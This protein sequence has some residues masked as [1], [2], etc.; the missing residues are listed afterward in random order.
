MGAPGVGGSAWALAD[1]ARHAGG[2]ADHGAA[3]CFGGGLVCLAC[4]EAALAPAAPG[5]P[6][7]PGG[8][9][10]QGLAG[11][12]LAREARLLVVLGQLQAAV[13]G[14]AEAGDLVGRR[15]LADSAELLGRAVCR[16]ETEAVTAAL[17]ELMAALLT[18][19]RAG[20]GGVR[21]VLLRK[22]WSELL[23]CPAG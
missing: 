3:R 5:G 12:A 9:E 14:D 18:L 23:V 17:H 11:G 13:E 20:E 4:F 15:C 8:G 16:S 21:D 1:P 22:C 2:P 19:P 6:A 7:G 10:A